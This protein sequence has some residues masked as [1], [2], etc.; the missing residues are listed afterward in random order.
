MLNRSQDS[1]SL[2]QLKTEDDA[3]EA[4][5]PAEVCKVA[6]V[7]KEEEQEVAEEDTELV[8]KKQ[9]IDNDFVEKEKFNRAHHFKWRRLILEG[10]SDKEV[11]E[12]FGLDEAWAKNRRLS[13]MYRMKHYSNKV[14]DTESKLNDPQLFEALYEQRQVMLQNN[15]W[16]D[17]EVQLW[18]SL[19]RQGL[20][21]EEIAKQLTSKTRE[22]ITNK[23]A[24]TQ[25]SL[26]MNKKRFQGLDDTFYKNLRQSQ[27]S[28]SE[29]WPKNLLCVFITLLIRPQLSLSDIARMIKAKDEQQ[30]RFRAHSLLEMMNNEERQLPTWLQ[31][32]LSKFSVDRHKLSQ[33]ISQKLG[34]KH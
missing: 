26:K 13:F 28:K 33:L 25:L 27:S 11:A 9:M 31:V 12:C 24:S 16:T 19:I 22:Q 14:H 15:K 10:K 17:A 21:D 18:I 2:L 1:S 29:I 32:R 7:I 30:C 8:F 5:K 6:G 23:R 20:D 4:P 34:I 3:L